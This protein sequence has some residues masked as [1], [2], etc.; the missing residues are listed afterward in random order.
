MVKDGKSNKTKIITVI[1]TIAVLFVLLTYSVIAVYF[2]DRFLF[3]TRVNGMKVSGKTVK[4]VE[5]M[6]GSQL[7]DYSIKI[8]ERNDNSEVIYGSDIGLENTFDDTLSSY[9]KNQNTIG[10][11]ASLFSKKNIELEKLIVYDKMKYEDVVS[12]LMC[13]SDESRIVQPEDAHISDYANGTYEIVPEVQGSLVNKD[14]LKEVL[15]S[16]ILSL[17]DEVNIDEA[18]CYEAPA[19]TSDDENLKNTCDVL[20]KYVSAD[21]KYTFGD[22]IEEVDGDMISEW[23]SYGED[24]SVSLDDT[25]IANYIQSLATKYNTIFTNRKFKTSYGQTVTVEGGDYGWWMDQITE[26]QKLKDSI[27]A[28]EQDTREPEY[29]QKAE[30]HG[31]KD[32]GDTY[33]EINI[34]AQHLYFY[35]DGKLIIESDFVSG[36]ET[37]GHATPS[38]TY[39]ITY[40]ERDATLNGE[41][42]STPVSYWMPFNMDIGLH[43]A[44]WRSKFG[45]FIY[46]KSGSHGCINLPVDVAKTIF[47]YIEKGDPV[48]VYRLPGTESKEAL[49]EESAKSVVSLIKSIGEVTLESESVITSARSKYDALSDAAKKYVTNID[50]LVNAEEQ[51]KALKETP[52]Q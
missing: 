52:A 45:G 36:T 46:Q 13:L 9:V 48:I 4:Q 44:G 43:D 12:G 10:W 42:Y 35:V 37:N 15:D 26:S 14:R 24:G 41:N 22:K 31:D 6:I 28:G 3:G 16:A 30:S 34:T 5:E 38:G 39:S 27:M 19:V 33:V 29:K 49:A 21:I 47:Q 23:I 11:F 1:V 2:K 17:S 32:Y 18:G 40:K 51:L 8:D 50:T 7:R 25:A 20:N